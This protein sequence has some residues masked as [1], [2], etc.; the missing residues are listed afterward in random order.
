[1]FKNALAFWIDHDSSLTND[2]FSAW[3][4]GLFSP[5][6]LRTHFPLTVRQFRTEHFD[7]GRRRLKA[8]S[9]CWTQWAE[10]PP[11]SSGSPPRPRAQSP[12]RYQLFRLSVSLV[13][14]FRFRPFLFH[15]Q[16]FV[17]FIK[18]IFN[19][20]SN[21][22]LNMTSICCFIRQCFNCLFRQMKDFCNTGYFSLKGHNCVLCLE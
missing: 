6:W 3:S 11:P 15:L 21:L 2:S 19:P 7:S 8:Q 17:S 22:K 4:H 9:R 18:D 5:S 12:K 16:L 13:L 1:M 20:K 10:Q 14:S